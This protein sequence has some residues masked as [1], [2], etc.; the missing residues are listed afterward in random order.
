MKK[1]VILILI[2]ASLFVFSLGI[3]KDKVLAE[4]GDTKITQ[5][6]IDIILDAISPQ[7][8][9]AIKK[10]DLLQK[11]IDTEIF[12]KEAIAKKFNET[13]KFKNKIELI[14]RDILVSIYVKELQNNMKI[15]DAE[16]EKK[17]KDQYSQKKL[18][19]AKHILFAK[20][21]KKDAEK[22][23][24][25][26]KKNNKLFDEIA[27]KESI[28]PSGKKGGDLGWFPKGSMVAEFEDAL[29]KMKKNEIKGLV[30]TQFGYHIIKFEDEKIDK[31][32]LAEVKKEIVESIKRENFEPYIKKM[33]KKLKKKYK[34][35]IFK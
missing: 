28:C 3:A 26:I 20:N 5:S 1:L 15:S 8:K 4:V 17:F 18:F 14:K 23:L 19:K 35:K 11:I 31:K 12:Y 10:E 33:L 13:K 9:A 2:I 22:A 6:T 25:K 32:K 16:I 21:K 29:A 27:K 34:I 7:Q 24:K 30:K